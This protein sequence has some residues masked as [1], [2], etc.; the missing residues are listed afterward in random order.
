[1]LTPSAGEEAALSAPHRSIG[2]RV[3]P[4]LSLAHLGRRVGGVVGAIAV[5]EIVVASGAVPSE[6]LPR[7]QAVISAIVS[8]R[9]A[10]LN[11]VAQSLGTWALSLVIATA[12]GSLAGVLVGISAIADQLSDFIVRMARSLPTLALIPVAILIAGAGPAMAIGL[13][14]IACFWPVFIN[15]KYGVRRIEPG[16]LDAARVA[17]YSKPLVVKRIIIPSALPS[18]ASGVRVAIGLGILVTVA[19]EL[20]AASGGLGEYVLQAQQLNLSA[21][22]YAGVIVGG[23]LGW[24]LNAL[25]GF[26]D[27]NLLHWARRGQGSNAF[28][29]SSRQRRLIELQ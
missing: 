16:Y 4:G 24:L 29:L 19:V 2:E 15:T 8:S 28:R 22:L 13:V 11:A 7:I 27:R 18:I 20:V 10:L 23:I 26:I 9:D 17:G 5:W 3:L 14:S 1:M 12:F 25:Y 6:Q 21:R